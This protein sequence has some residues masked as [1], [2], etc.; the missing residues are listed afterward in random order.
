[1]QK[2]F[3]LLFIISFQATAITSIDTSSEKE[4]IH[5]E[6]I[7]NFNQKIKPDLEPSSINGTLNGSSEISGSFIDIETN[8]LVS[9]N[10]YTWI[11]LKRRVNS[12]SEWE[13]HENYFSTGSSFHFTDLPNGEYY[14]SIKSEF[15]L[16]Q[17]QQPIFMPTLWHPQGQIVNSFSTIPND[18]ILVVNADNSVISADF[19][20]TP[21]AILAVTNDE[22][23]GETLSYYMAINNESEVFESIRYITNTFVDQVSVNNTILVSYL[24]IGDYRFYVDANEPNFTNIAHVNQ[25]FGYGECYNC[26]LDLLSGKGEVFSLS[27]FERKIIDVELTE[28]ASILGEILIEEN[29]SD[30]SYYTWM[31]LTSPQGAIDKHAILFDDEVDSGEYQVSGL[32]AGE[33]YARFLRDGYIRDSFGDV[34]CPYFAC[35]DYNSKPIRIVKGENR[36]N[37]DK[38]LRKG[39][40]ISGTVLDAETGLTLEP[41]DSL[42]FESH[43]IEILDENFNIVGGEYVHPERQ[44][45][46]YLRNA[47]PKGKYYV[48]TGSTNANISNRSYINQVYP[49]IECEGNICDFS[50]AELI[51]IDSLST[52]EN[53]NFSL[54]KGFSISGKVKSLTDGNAVEGIEVV[55]VNRQGLFVDVIKTNSNGEY[56]LR[57]L[58]SGKYHVRTYN[59]NKKHYF[60]D[61]QKLNVQNSWVNQT[62]PKLNCINDSC[63]MFNASII[64]IAN[65]NV[66]GIDFSLDK[67]YSIN[68]FVKNKFA[69]IGVSKIEIKIYTD[70]NEYIGS[71]YTDEHGYYTTPALV[72]GNYKL[73]TSNPMHYQNQAFGGYQCGIGECN[74]LQSE[75]V[76]IADSSLDNIDFELTSGQD[77]YPQLSGLWYNQEQSGHGLQLEVIKSKGTATLYASWYVVKDGQP[78]WLTGTGPLNKELAFVDLSISNGNSFPPNFDPETVDL[79]PWGS[80]QF[81]FNDMDHAQMSWTTETEGFTNGSIDLTRLTNLSTT[82]NQDNSIDAC[83][84]GTFYNPDQSG[85]GVMLEVLGE[86]AD[87]MALTWFTYNDN[88]QYWLL[89]TGAVSDKEANLSAVYSSGSDFPPDFDSNVN[90]IVQWGD[91]NLTKVDNDH[92]Q[93]EWTPNADHL[94]F[95]SGIMNMQRLTKIE[96][97]GCD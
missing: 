71:Y 56:E 53:I 14:L 13:S 32:A 70:F 85:H 51:E 30:N 64:E 69:G 35:E 7:E 6:I 91:F 68:G 90:Y 25:I 19:Q 61:N 12:S 60:F 96:G 22:N 16:D 21:A 49:N 94:D 1:M 77:Y 89:A 92:I 17:E 81:K 9:D 87:S 11:S 79:T 45:S 57:G 59:G 26:K 44:N 93:L 88:K 23:N 34:H 42:L 74:A 3:L 5:N 72:P 78:M 66:S 28:G 40:R 24:P 43:F 52:I 20:L 27:K 18:S 8:E 31:Y 76:T 47:L 65:E 82:Q 63:S 4:L 33:Y 2:L 55:A 46:F 83:L 10:F 80:L 41:D 54:N 36:V 95:G 73:I 50:K 58:K 29:E 67:G 38:L 39:T 86:N 97:L 84:S 15:I 48:K 75:T 37:V 62:H